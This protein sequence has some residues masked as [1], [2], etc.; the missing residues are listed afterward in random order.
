[1]GREK[2]ILLPKFKKVLTELGQNLIRF[3][4]GC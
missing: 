2:P 4:S 1:M 3:S